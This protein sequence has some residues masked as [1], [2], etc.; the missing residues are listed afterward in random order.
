MCKDPNCIGSGNL[1][2]ERLCDFCME[3]MAL[4][5]QAN[6]GISKTPFEFTPEEKEFIQKWLDE[7]KELM[8]DLVKAGD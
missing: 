8:D 7:N 5:N 1:N 2:S 4:K 3:K 6:F